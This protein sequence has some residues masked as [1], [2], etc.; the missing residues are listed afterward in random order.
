MQI[1]LGGGGFFFCSK[2]ETGCQSSWLTLW[3][4][5]SYSHRLV[6]GS[7]HFPH[8]HSDTWKHNTVFTY[9]S[10]LCHIRISHIWDL[11]SSREQP[12]SDSRN[13]RMGA[14]AVGK[15]GVL[16]FSSQSATAN[17]SLV[18][19]VSPLLHIYI[20]IYIYICDVCVTLAACVPVHFLAKVCLLLCV[21]GAFTNILRLPYTPLNVARL[22]AA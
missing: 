19:A 20:Y 7:I 1:G 6:H 4:A 2:F 3:H 11:G 8:S 18:S 15:P 14:G 9:F 12:G 22:S 10:N 21:C 17:K 13:V 5:C 16:L